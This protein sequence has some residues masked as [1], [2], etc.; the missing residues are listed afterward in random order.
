[1][2]AFGKDE[3]FFSKRRFKRER[4][5]ELIKENGISSASVDAHFMPPTPSS[6]ISCYTRYWCIACSALGTPCTKHLSSL[7]RPPLKARRHLYDTAGAFA[8]ARRR[9][10]VTHCNGVEMPPYGALSA[11][12]TS[13]IKPEIHTLPEGDR[14]TATSNPHKIGRIQDM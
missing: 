12:M 2:E 4:V 14:T 8:C 3:R 7:M 1:M 10:D 6:C 13:S 11:N 9:N 5:N